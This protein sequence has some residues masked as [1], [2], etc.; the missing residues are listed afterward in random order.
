MTRHYMERTLI[1]GTWKGELG[2]GLAPRELEF[3]L[4]VAQGQTAKQIA[5]SCGISPGTVVKR[6]S[7]AMLKLGVTRQT[8]MVAEAIRRRIITPVCIALAPAIVIHAGY[9][10]SGRQTGDPIL[11]DESEDGIFLA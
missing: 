10:A 11:P 6:L 8:A 7:S 1:N 3:V 5:K 9:I 4:S 2:L